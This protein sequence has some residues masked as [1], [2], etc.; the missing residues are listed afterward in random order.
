MQK[1]VQDFG[2]EGESVCYVRINGSVKNIFIIDVY[3]PHRDHVTPCQD[4]AI[5]DVENVL[6][7]VPQG[8][9]IYIMG[10]F[11]EQLEGNIKST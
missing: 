7:R 8:D 10:D 4:D 9:C 5:K 11:N 3:L 1:K 2:S 6:C